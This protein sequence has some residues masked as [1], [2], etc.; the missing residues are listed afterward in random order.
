MERSRSAANESRAES[1]D[2]ELIA[3]IEASPD[4]IA[5]AIEQ[6]RFREALHELM[7]LARAGN[8][9][10]TETEPWKV[11]KVDPERVER[12]LHLCIQLISNL[13]VL[14][15]PFLPFT[16]AKLSS[17]LGLSEEL[18]WNDTGRLDFSR[19]ALMEKPEGYKPP[20]PRDDNWKRNKS[21]R[22]GKPFKKR[23][24]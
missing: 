20:P 22:D 16:A 3:T 9:Y 8:K 12:I 7:N 5:K 23:R 6:Y 10:L 15:E 18:K 2:S 14:G 13:S 17:I 11:F 24:F 19:K 4:K 21:G 1:V